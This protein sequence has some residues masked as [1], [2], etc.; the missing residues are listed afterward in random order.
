MRLLLGLVALAL[1]AAPPNPRLVTLADFPD[2]GLTMGPRDVHVYLPPGYAEGNE[3]YRVIYFNDGEGVFGSLDGSRGVQADADYALDRLLEEKLVYPAILVA[4]ANAKG[5]VNGRLHD[6]IPKWSP[7]APG[8]ADQYF[9]FLT[10][11][12][13]PYID[14]HF[15]T[16]P[17]APYTGI[18]GNSLGGLAAFYFGY[19]HPETFGMAICFSPSLWIADSQLV[20]EA[21]ADGVRRH[22]TRFW[23]DGGE[24]DSADIETISPLM[25][26]LLIGKGWREG[27]DAAF[28]LGYGQI[29]GRAAMRERLRDALYFMLRRET[30][31]VRGLALRPLADPS[32][33]V[34][35]LAAA[36]ERALVWPEVRYEHGFYLNSVTVPLQIDD[37]DV[38]K[39]DDAGPGRIR[40]I[41]A[42]RTA[43]RAEY[44]GWQAQLP[45]IGYTPG[46]YARFSVRRAPANV[47]VD[48]K[49]GEWQALPY[50]IAPGRDDRSAS[51][52]FAVA[53]DD[54]YLYAAVAVADPR[55]VIRPDRPSAEQDGVELWLDARPDPG[56]AESKAWADGYQASFLLLRATPSPAP[57]PP[58]SLRMTLPEGVKR[59]VRMTPSGYDA[60]FAIPTEV[61]NQLQGAAWREFRWNIHITDFVGAGE[62]RIDLWW[63]P[64]WRSMDAHAGSGTFGRE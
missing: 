22:A 32:A 8:L 40:T 59:A 19:R 33:A 39:I 54:R 29:H 37:T 35:D 25:T 21:A 16:L 11:R 36:G 45:V 48:G 61:L 38:A 1:A 41:A 51:A 64:P 46:E 53:Y 47:A 2:G 10:T 3:R 4:V 44:R 58:P 57:A 62:P 7:F 12:L 43:L 23:I 49:L 13:K 56:R 42:G 27:E 31:A 52:R 15:R 18:A 14:S 17:E 34:L 30:P 55:I 20:R 9:I 60:E 63:Q 26:K 24:K 50:S 6:L 5:V 28:Q